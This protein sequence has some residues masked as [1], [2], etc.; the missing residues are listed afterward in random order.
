MCDKLIKAILV[1]LFRKVRQGLLENNRVTKY[2]VYAIGEII[3]VVVGILI[4]V[5]INNAN[6]AVKT[7]RVET[8]TLIEI[9]TSLQ[10]NLDEVLKMKKAH[11]EQIEIFDRLLKHLKANHPYHD[12]L[13]MYFGRFYNYYTPLFDY[14]PYETLKSR[15]VELI[16]NDTV[17]NEIINVYEKVIYRITDG[18]GKFEDENNAGL[19]MPFFAKHFEIYNAIPSKVRPNDYQALKGKNEYKNILS[20]LK[21]VRTFGVHICGTSKEQIQKTIDLIS[22]EIEQRQD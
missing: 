6:E 21:A 19:I 18:L 4:A 17:K 5:T 13:D 20:I 1:K 14:A 9:K 7:E 15:G 11:G 3:L 22:I 10:K 12:S 16:Q 2:I 8:Q